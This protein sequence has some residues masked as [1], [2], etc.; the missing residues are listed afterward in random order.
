MEVEISGDQEDDCLDRL[1]ASESAR[2]TL[3]MSIIFD[4]YIHYI[5]PTKAPR[6]Q[7]DNLEC[8]SKLRKVFDNAPIDAITPQHTDTTI[9]E[10][11]YRRI[12]ET[13]KPT[14]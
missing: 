7:K 1:D 12:G 11:V 3:V 5:I 2:T 9:T 13:V 6:T 14:K 8:M 4:R 10:K